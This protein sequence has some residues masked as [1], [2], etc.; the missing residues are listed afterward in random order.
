MITLYYKANST[1]SRSAVVWFKE[2]EIEVC[3]KRINYISKDELIHLL[4]LTDNGFMSILKG[5]KKA[6][7]STKAQLKYFHELNFNEALEYIMKHF[8]LVK[9]SIIFDENKLL[10]GYNEEVIRQFL[11]KEYRRLNKK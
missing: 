1:S 6:L 2:K 3:A 10:V 8:E 4:F 11:P 9:V 7:E 5:E